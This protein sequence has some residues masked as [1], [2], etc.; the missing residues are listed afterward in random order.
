[1]P[2]RPVI[3][4]GTLVFT[5]ADPTPPGG[6]G[7]W[8]PTDPR[9]TNPIPIYP[10]GTPN[11]PGTGGPGNPPGFWGP[12]DPRPSNP[13]NLPWWALAGQQPP[14]YWGPPGPW[15]GNPI[16]N[17]PGVG[18]NPDPPG[19]PGSGGNIP[20][21]PIELPPKVDP[22]EGYQWTQVYS[23]PTQGGWEWALVPSE[24]K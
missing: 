7:I 9:P 11:P 12:N 6:L 16:A 17:A 10:G 22:P 21:H 19:F 5:D 23:P 24:S 1:M 18:P 2:A 8:G 14:G 13:I 20:T 4:V 3:I 15:I